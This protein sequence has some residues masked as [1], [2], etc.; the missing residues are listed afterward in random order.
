MERPEHVEVV[1][2]WT[3]EGGIRKIGDGPWRVIQPWGF[4]PFI[5]LD[6]DIRWWGWTSWVSPAEAKLL[7]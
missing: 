4:V 7:S 3:R 6:S 1:E 5:V 2:R